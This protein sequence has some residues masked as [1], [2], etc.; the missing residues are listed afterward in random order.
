MYELGNGQW[1]IPGLRLLLEDILPKNN[2]V[3]DYKIEHVFPGIG[4]RVMLL[5]ARRIMQEGV[6]TQMI[7]I[8]I[9]DITERNKK[10]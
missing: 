4:R 7:L 5:N 9:E 8:A 2:Q 1:D 10:G 3:D 6:G